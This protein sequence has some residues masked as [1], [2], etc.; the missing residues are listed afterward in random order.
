M[1]LEISSPKQNSADGMRKVLIVDDYLD[2][3]KSLCELLCE[4]FDCQY[5]SE[6]SEALKKM[7]EWRPDAVLLDYKMPG[8]SGVELSKLMRENSLLRNTP[9]IF[10]SGVAGV[11]E[12]IIA[13]EH[14]ADD[15]V[16]KPFNSKEL[17][18]RI[19]ARIDKKSQVVSELV[20]DNLRMDL[21]T[22]QVFVDEV[23]AD[24][25]PKQ[26]EILKLLLENKNSLVTREQCLK[27]IWNGT[28]VTTRNVDSQI[29]YLK[30]KISNF[31][32]KIIAVPGLGYRLE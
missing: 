1:D 29:N 32:G 2:S 4:D 25:T 30:R 26:F 15:F 21:L 20:S 11:D 5:T 23:E 31:K 27:K 14:G 18:L 3:C 12:R 28:E 22:R 19:K 10:I 6:S 8:L 24:L 13:F 7:T 16:T 17:T 9:V